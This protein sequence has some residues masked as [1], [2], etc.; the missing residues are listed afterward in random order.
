[1]SVFRFP[2][3]FF[4]SANPVTAAIITKRRATP[5][6]KTEWAVIRLE[7]HLSVGPEKAGAFHFDCCTETG[8]SATI[9]VITTITINK[10]RE[11]LHPAKHR[12]GVFFFP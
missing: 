7:N 9:T 12:I 2:F 4:I 1:M 11:E 5:I 3:L 10:R 8:D 6:P